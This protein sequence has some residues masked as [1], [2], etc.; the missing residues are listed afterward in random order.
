ML[1]RHVMWEATVSTTSRQFLI[2]ISKD[3]MEHIPFILMKVGMST[4]WVSWHNTLSFVEYH[5]FQTKIQKNDYVL[6]VLKSRSQPVL[7]YSSLSMGSQYPVNTK[8]FHHIVRMF[9]EMCQ[10]CLCKH[11]LNIWFVGSLKCLHI[12]WCRY[13]TKIIIK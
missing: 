8:Y 5:Q 4:P 12:V 1:Q 13:L 6:L 7:L 3:V 2:V 11:Q 9:V 10:K